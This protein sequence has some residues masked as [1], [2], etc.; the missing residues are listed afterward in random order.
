[1]KDFSAN[2][3]FDAFLPELHGTAIEKSIE[4]LLAGAYP[5]DKMDLIVRYIVQSGYRFVNDG[6]LASP[7]QSW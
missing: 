6:L 2:L 7:S 5:W 1:M 3:N 4:N